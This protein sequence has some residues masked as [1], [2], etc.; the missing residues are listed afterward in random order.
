MNYEEDICLQCGAKE[1]EKHDDRAHG[2]GRYGVGGDLE[3]KGE[4]LKKFLEG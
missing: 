3:L 2:S 1:G 4:D